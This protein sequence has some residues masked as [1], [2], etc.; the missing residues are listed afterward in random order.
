MTSKQKKN[1]FEG[2]AGTENPLE[3]EEK[4]QYPSMGYS[5]K[6]RKFFVDDDKLDSV[7]LTILAYRQCKEFGEKDNEGNFIP[8]Q[9]CNI[10]TKRSALDLSQSP[11]VR[12]RLQLLVFVFGEYRVF[13]INSATGINSFIP[14]NNAKYNPPGIGAGIM[15]RLKEYNIAKKAEHELN[16]TNYC[17]KLNLNLGET[18]QAGSGRNTSDACAVLIDGEP[19]FVGN[20]LVVQHANFLVDDDIQGWINEWQSKTDTNVS[21]EPHEQAY[22]DSSD[23]DTETEEALPADFAF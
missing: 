19:E 16:F 15:P 22:T 5:N 17:W 20:D 6:M 4:W 1:D 23:V 3:Q 2:F 9:R 14:S 21:L 11:D 8:H 13:G 10:Y 7:A 12:Y 18:F